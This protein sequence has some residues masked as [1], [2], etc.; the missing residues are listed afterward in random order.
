MMSSG[1]IDEVLRPASTPDDEE[2]KG[3]HRIKR[4]AG[5]PNNSRYIHRTFM[6]ICEDLTG[7]PPSVSWGIILAFFFNDGKNSTHL[8]NRY[9]LKIPVLIP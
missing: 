1:N 4:V 3:L 5:Q 6:S 7:I 9:Y 8:A 2:D